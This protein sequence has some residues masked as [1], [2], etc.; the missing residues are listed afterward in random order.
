MVYNT[1][2]QTFPT[3]VI[4]GMAGFRERPYFEMEELAREPVRVS[5][6]TPPSQPP[7][8]GT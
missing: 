4:A 1:R 7:A 2:T 6:T 5:F 3:S 8:S